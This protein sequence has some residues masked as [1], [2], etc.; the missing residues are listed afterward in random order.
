MGGRYRNWPL[1]VWL[2]L[3]AMTV[4]DALWLVLTPLS[5]APNDI[6]MLAESIAS[7]GVLIAVAY[8]YREHPT[9]F[10]LLSGVGIT[11]ASW[12]LLRLLNHLTMSIT[13]PLA[14]SRLASADAAIGF[15]W[16]AYVRWVDDHPI[17]LRLMGMTYQNLTLYSCAAFLLLLVV[18]GTERA[19]EFVLLF[20]GAAILT[21]LVGM[22]MPARGA[23][24]FYAPSPSIFHHIVAAGMGTYFW[25]PIEALRSDPHHVLAL[26]NL[27]G[28]V[29]IPSFHTAM[30]VIMIWCSRGVRRLFIASLALNTLMISGTPIYGGHYA[31]DILAGA[32]MVLAL[33]AIAHRRWIAASI[34]T[35]YGVRENSRSA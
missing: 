30:G 29:A 31:V 23:M 16:L 18:Q 6:P 5:L 9:F 27:P 22:L 21:I 28:L 26:D 2:A 20:L 14:D 4:V 3:G 15:D 13:F 25:P 35:L 1:W 24:L 11:L 8:R 7:V 33:V 10:T 12:P 34:R 17:L 19:R 32:G